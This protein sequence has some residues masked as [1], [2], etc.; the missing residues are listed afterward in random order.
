MNV[1][2][3]VKDS[4][5]T[6]QAAEMYGIKIRRG[7]MAC[8][9]FHNDKTPSMKIDRRFHCFGCQADGDVIDFTARL[10]GLSSKDAAKKL[11]ADFGIHYD[12]RNRTAPKPVKRKV[13]AELQF[14]Q[15]VDRC[16]LAYCDYLHLL[17]DWQAAYAP[18]SPDEE[19][20]PRFVEA[21][22]KKTYVEY[23]LDVL[24]TGTVQEQAEI[25]TEHGKEVPAL[26][27]RVRDIITAAS[28]ERGSSSR[29]IS[30]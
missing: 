5:T 1:F 3:A 4:V 23:L 8:C 12:G 25:L 10:F 29:D 11:A 27:Q 6:R 20:D 9:P 7:G 16:Y 19:W 26:E 18:H 22:Q 2:E 14:R 30:Y 15:A 13:D 21:L 28:K 17:Q 24:L